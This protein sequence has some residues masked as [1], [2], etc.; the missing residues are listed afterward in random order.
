MGCP[1]E[2]DV[3]TKKLL[4]TSPGFSEFWVVC[5]TDLWVSFRKRG[6]FG[7]EES[8]VQSAGANSRIIGNLADGLQR[9]N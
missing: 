7:E 4:D 9:F 3:S 5:G 8:G 2:S 6:V 1:S